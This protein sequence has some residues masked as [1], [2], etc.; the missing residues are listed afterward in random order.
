MFRY[1]V[2]YYSQP[3]SGTQ[4]IANP[5]SSVTKFLSSG[6]S[7]TYRQTA[8]LSYI[9]NGTFFLSR[10]DAP[11]A[12][13][14][15]GATGSGSL[16]YRLTERTT[17][18]GT[19]SHSYYTYQHGAGDATM[20]G[21]YFNVSHQFPQFWSANFDAGFTRT[22]S[23]GFIE[24]PITFIINGQPVTGYLKGPY[25]QTS[26]TPTLRGSVSRRLRRIVTTVSGGQGVSPGNGVYL[27]S[28]NQFL[29][30]TV[31]YSNQRSNI[32]A[33][34][35]YWHLTSLT[36]SLSNSYGTASFGGSYSYTLARHIAAHIR[37]DYFRYGSVSTYSGSGYNRISFGVTFSSENIPLTLY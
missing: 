23:S 26:F 29:S 14:S 4:A 1:G 16:R 35:G 7:L 18:G 19:Y 25:Q 5:F 13:G 11:G 28:R 17:I 2:P 15:T 34:G 8:R 37:Y 3:D 33:S 30:G 27:A 22:D 24:T 31:S 10:Y 21:G 6:I 12:I 36:H 32:S 9:F 20:D